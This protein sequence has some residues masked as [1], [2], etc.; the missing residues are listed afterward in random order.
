[1]NFAL[2]NRTQNV[3]VPRIL[4]MEHGRRNTKISCS[5]AGYTASRHETA[6]NWTRNTNHENFVFRRRGYDLGTRNGLTLNAKRERENFASARKRPRTRNCP[7]LNAKRETRKFRVGLGDPCEFAPSS[8][9]SAGEGL[10]NP[11]SIK[12]PFCRLRPPPRD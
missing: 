12:F 11:Q 7:K 2:G 6:E 5:A 10:R 4:K 8:R 9:R 1:M 3:R